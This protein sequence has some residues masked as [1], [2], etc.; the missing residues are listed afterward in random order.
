MMELRDDVNSD[1]IYPV[2]DWRQ[3]EYRGSREVALE[4]V[5]RRG[6]A[7]KRDQKG[8]SYQFSDS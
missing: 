5:V 1:N 8:A 4:H 3:T 6:K 7:N 2:T